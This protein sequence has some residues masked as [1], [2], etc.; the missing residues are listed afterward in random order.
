MF[1][2]FRFRDV[3]GVCGRIGKEFV[4]DSTTGAWGFCGETIFFGPVAFM[5]AVCCVR[6]LSKNAG[7]SAGEYVCG[8]G[9]RTGSPR[10]IANDEDEGLIFGGG[11]V[12]YG[13]DGVVR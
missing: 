10:A 11:G 9:V 4:L 6:K 5:S 1:T 7:D 3:C 8:I 13:A 12:G 2:A